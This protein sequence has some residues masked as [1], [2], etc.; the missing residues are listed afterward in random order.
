MNISFNKTKN[1]GFFLLL[2]IVVVTCVV[3]YLMLSETS[4]K[5]VD[6]MRNRENRITKWFSLIDLIE[7]SEKSLQKNCCASACQINSVTENLH[8]TIKIIE[9]IKTLTCCEIEKQCIDDVN[10]Q[11]TKFRQA[12]YF[13]A[14]EKELGYQN[15]D[16]VKEA[17]TIA[18]NAAQESVLA[19][20][21][22]LQKVT[23]HIKRDVI[24]I[25]SDA[26]EAKSI[27]IYCLTIAIA[28]TFIVAIFTHFA[29]AHPVKK[30]VEATEHNSNGDLNFKADIRTKDRFGKLAIAFNTMTDQLR[31]S[32]QQ[33][34]NSVEQANF[35][36]REAQSANEAKSM[37]LA[38]MSHEIRTPMNAIIGFSTIL[39]DEKLDEDLSSYVDMI[40]TNGEN[41]LDL[42]NNILDFSK[43][44]AGMMQAEFIETDV[45]E[46][47]SSIDASIKLA[48]TTKGIYFKIAIDKRVPQFIH[49]DPLRIKQCLINLASNAV[50]FTETGSVAINVSTETR[51]DQPFIRFEVEDT[52]IGIIPDLQST[53]FESFN[54]ADNSHTRQY[55]GTGLG[56]AITKRLAEL[57]GGDITLTSQPSKGS[58]F[59]LTIPTNTNP[60]AKLPQPANV[61]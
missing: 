1:W 46:I 2:L 31:K 59:T 24:D 26:D 37:F 9:E 20:K 48:A 43:V 7:A 18:I 55:G 16:A 14:Q 25:F 32:H 41:L 5:I 3:S 47:L 49:T 50:K 17:R 22:T 44:E 36:A 11:L 60:P 51:N 52:G 39:A 12:A 8:S 40:K 53:I 10:N 38:N 54:Q 19:C 4:T 57:L 23:F 13:L 29:L 15:S 61:S 6:T 34:E 21:Q 33:L 28:T 45:K 58:T 56:L 30:L 42:I 35:L 27:L